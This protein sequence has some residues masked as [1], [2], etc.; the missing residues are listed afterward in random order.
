VEALSSPN[1]LAGAGWDQVRPF[2]QELL[3]RPVDAAWLREWSRL[4]D[5]IAEAAS[6][7]RAHYYADTQDP[8]LKAAELRLNSEIKPAAAD[9]AARL[10]RR[11]LDSGYSEPDFE[12]VLSQMRNQ[13]GILVPENVPLL[14]EEAR[15][16]E[17]WDATM[18][19]LA[20]DWEGRE[21]PRMSLVNHQR[22]PD[23]D[24][25]ERAWLAMVEPVIARFRELDDLFASLVDLR[26]RIARNAGCENYSEYGRRM[27]NR[28]DF[29]LSETDRMY[30]SVLEA[31][32]PVLGT[33]RAREA[34]RLGVER[35]RPWD[36]MAP[37]SPTELR[38]YEATDDLTM[39]FER[40]FG[41]L[42]P[43]LGEHFAGM[44]RDGLL[45]V[46]F[47]PRAAPV[48]VNSRLHFSRRAH[49]FMS[50]PPGDLAVSVL[51]H[52]AGHSFHFL[53]AAGYPLHWQRLYNSMAAEFASTTM[54]L[55]VMDHMARPM[56]GFYS[57]E[58][59]RQS[60][61]LRLREAVNLPVR[62]ALSHAF[63]R[64]VYDHPTADEAD[65]TAVWR[66][67][68]GRQVEGEDWN[69][70]QEQFDALRCGLGTIYTWAF[71]DFDYM[72]GWLGALQV[73][74]NYLQ[75]PQ[76]AIEAYLDALGLGNTRTVPEIYA[77]AGAR[78]DL[79]PKSM[80]DLAGFLAER[81]E[82]LESSPR[83]T[84]G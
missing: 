10:S 54:Q 14:G 59:A 78:I 22:S 49:I 62:Q 20:A 8:A 80:S 3:E 84:T 73:W 17:R 83:S 29:T 69:G 53:E 43:R 52:E 33:W 34:S 65:R 27:R 76:G 60:A 31:W 47:R 9:M 71:Y 28:I 77:A 68:W 50:L 56:G 24:V 35:L 74:R 32:L 13:T 82:E 38:P 39:T 64:W 67:T 11:L 44:R 70:I 23:R 72:V 30:E 58:D 19:A 81:L 41:G 25:R 26:V 4:E 21:V 16:S 45:D 48:A 40:V 66:R 15:L 1:D 63:Q 75:D 42:H 37:T 55:L 57:E 2:Y 7:A 18:G 5:L 6:L 46:G 51:S 61:G 36:F 12:N 79:D